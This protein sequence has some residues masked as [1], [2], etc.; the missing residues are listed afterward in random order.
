[1]SII[2]NVVSQKCYRILELLQDIEIE[3]FYLG[4]N[5]DSVWICIQI[6]KLSL[7]V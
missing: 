6:G 5:K 3:V 1:M 2:G 7:I 4:R